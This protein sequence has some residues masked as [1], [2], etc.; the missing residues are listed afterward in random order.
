MSVNDDV[1]ESY[2]HAA[3]M[4]GTLDTHLGNPSLPG[5][6]QMSS[7]A[8]ARVVAFD[9]VGRRLRRWLDQRTD[10]RLT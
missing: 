4:H 10:P 2:E 9:P 8:A 7:L 5:S 3:S 6:Y 1:V